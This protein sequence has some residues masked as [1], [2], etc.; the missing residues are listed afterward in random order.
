MNDSF[1]ASGEVNGSFTTSRTPL[2]AR[3]RPVVADG[4]GSVSSGPSSPIAWAASTI[5]G[6]P[7]RPSPVRPPR[8]RS[9]PAPQPASRPAGHVPCTP[10]LPSAQPLA[11]A[12]GMRGLPG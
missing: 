5:V 12:G 7:G 9:A 3:G 10:G 8:Q 6:T 4:G 11:P 1:M 2:A